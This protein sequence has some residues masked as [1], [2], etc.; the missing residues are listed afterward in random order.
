M[1]LDYSNVNTDYNNSIHFKYERKPNCNSFPRV[2]RLE[3]EEFHFDCMIKDAKYDFIPTLLVT[4]VKYKSKN[5]RVL[6]LDL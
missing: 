3:D 6:M 4:N 5:G 2:I 1:R